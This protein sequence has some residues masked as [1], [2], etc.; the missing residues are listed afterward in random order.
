[1]ATW[2]RF[3]WSI[4]GDHGV[5]ATGGCTSSTDRR[6]R[7]AHYDITVKLGILDEREVSS[8]GYVEGDV[9]SRGP[10]NPAT[11]LSASKET[12]QEVSWG[13]LHSWQGWTHDRGRRGK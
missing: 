8:Y 5:G 4:P 3:R 11:D 7:P 9:A 10:V 1:M 6:S 12:P 2:Y 13:A